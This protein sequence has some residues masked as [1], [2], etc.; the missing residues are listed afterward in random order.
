MSRHR[1]QRNWGGLTA[2]A[3]GLTA[4]ALTG[5]YFV[6][7]TSASAATAS[8]VDARSA[9][10]QA[11]GTAVDPA[12]PGARVDGTVIT[13]PEQDKIDA[14]IAAAEAVDSYS[15]AS[16]TTAEQEGIDSAVT[17]AKNPA[18]DGPLVH[19]G[20]VITADE[21]AKIDST[22]AAADAACQGPPGK[23]GIDARI[24][25]SPGVCA[26]AVVKPD[27]DR[28]VRVVVLIPCPAVVPPAPPAAPRPG[29]QVV[30]IPTMPAAPVPQTVTGNLPVTH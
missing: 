11:Q 20:S 1:V 18:S 30:V 13:E 10:E 27:P 2:G 17:A 25:L 6:A 8:C 24:V 3:A 7:G 9:Y 15:G 28:L 22:K 14:K 5:G 19:D 4:L 16:I 26:R 29:D 12:G 23:D 21:Q